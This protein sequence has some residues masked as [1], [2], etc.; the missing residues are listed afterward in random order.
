M[1]NLLLICAPQ[2]PLYSPEVGKFLIQCYIYFSFALVIYTDEIIRKES[3]QLK[4][5]FN[6]T[7]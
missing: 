2:N 3:N 7:A 1:L 4:P 6:G 5:D